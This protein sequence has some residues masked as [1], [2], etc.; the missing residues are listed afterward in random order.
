MRYFVV[1]VFLLFWKKRKR[2]KVKRFFALI[3]FYISF[4]NFSFSFLNLCPQLKQTSKSFAISIPHS[5][6]LFNLLIQLILIILF[7][8]NFSMWVCNSIFQN[9]YLYPSVY[10]NHCP[11][12]DGYVFVLRKLYKVI[13]PQ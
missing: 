10:F 3:V 7:I 9:G 8:K 6:H 12:A 1:I 2:L 11:S 13:I 4:P 5:G